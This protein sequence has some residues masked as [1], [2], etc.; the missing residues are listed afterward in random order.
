MREVRS[1]KQVV[2]EMVTEYIDAVESVT[3]LLQRA[4]E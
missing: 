4:A 2:Q 3:Q 1:V